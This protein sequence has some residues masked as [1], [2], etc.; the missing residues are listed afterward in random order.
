MDFRFIVFVISRKERVLLLILLTNKTQGACFGLN[1]AGNNRLA[2][3]I[4]GPSPCQ[5]DDQMMAS[6]KAFVLE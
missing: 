3:R 4:L 5:F 1:S 2:T 6:A